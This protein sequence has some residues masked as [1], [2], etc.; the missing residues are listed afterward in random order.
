M[1]PE[2]RFEGLGRSD[3]STVR[4]VLTTGARFRSTPKW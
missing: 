1:A 4:S 2:G 3:W